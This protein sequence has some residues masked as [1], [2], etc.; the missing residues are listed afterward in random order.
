MN[1]NLHTSLERRLSIP[2]RS[3]FTS[4][5]QLSYNIDDMHQ[6]HRLHR[7]AVLLTAVALTLAACGSGSSDS[8][9][10]TTNPEPAASDPIDTTAPP[11]TDPPVADP[12]ATDPPVTDPP[13]TDPP[14]TDPPVTD[15][16]TTDAPPTTDFVLGADTVKQE[17]GGGFV[18]MD[19]WPGWEVVNASE[20]PER[21]FETLD[22]EP[23]TYDP[24][25]SESVVELESGDAVL[26]VVRE[27]R[28][29]A[30]DSLTTFRS[31]MIDTFSEIEPFKIDAPQTW[32]GIDGNFT[33]FSFGSVRT[34]QIDDQFV[35]VLSFGVDDDEL[36]DQVNAMI[37]TIEFDT[38]VIGPLDHSTLMEFFTSAAGP[39]FSASIQVPA[40]WQQDEDAD[41]LQFTDPL[42]G[43]TTSITITPTQGSVDA[44]VDL[45]SSIDLLTGEPARVDSNVNDLDYAVLWQGEPSEANRAVIVTDDGAYGAIILV[46]TA[47]RIIGDEPAG[48]RLID[49]IIGSVFFGPH[50]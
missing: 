37:E 22:A 34:G 27:R 2:A 43:S 32:A 46:N 8:A 21:D 38:S 50:S 5:S 7:S 47:I 9:D 44:M 19:V 26:A 41:G 12:P 42:A 1:A 10:D 39:E 36:T 33:S 16:P 15:P 17:F 31:G 28:F 6:S 18:R 48:G 20:V 35:S 14:A 30:V 13:A 49:Q 23:W 25:E 11:A 40:T 45:V 29:G 3:R 24:D 4:G